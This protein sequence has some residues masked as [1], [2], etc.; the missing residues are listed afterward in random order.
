MN[1]STFKAL[2]DPT[3]REILSMLK[4]GDMT[5]GEIASH[6]QMSKPSI[7][8]HL[9]T[10]K[11]AGLVEDVKEGQNVIYSLNL[12]VL[13]EIASWVMGLCDDVGEKISQTQTER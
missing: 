7:S 1:S 9:S 5:A 4:Q 6:F 2:S 12:T 3:R 13:A 8:H 11:N 10:L